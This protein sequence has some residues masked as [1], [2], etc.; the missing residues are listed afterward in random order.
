[1][2]AFLPFAAAEDSHLSVVA[3]T[4]WLILA[5]SMGL[6]GGYVLLL[7][8]AYTG[9]DLSQVYPIMRGINPL[10]VPIIGM[11]ALGERLGFVAW[12]GVAGIVAGI[13]LTGDFTVKSFGRSLANPSI[14][15]A[16]TVGGMISGYTVV[17]KVALSYFPPFT[18]NLATN[19]GN[20]FSLSFVVWNS[21]SL[22]RE[23]KVNW[24]TILLG[25]VLAPGGYLLFL[26]AMEHM[27]VSRIAPMRE[28]G[29]VFGT[30][31]GIFILH[32]RQ[33][34]RR[35]AASIIITIGIILLAG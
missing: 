15:L 14:L 18:L 24:T 9:G 34:R 10:L 17:D 30:L 12:I 25:G 5:G 22:I 6:H 31:L 33:G 28:I 1:V 2:I 8:R 35:I 21:G 29:T 16:L 26:H 23:W 7:A 32:E 13:I 3:L 19:L 20:L 27:P 11:V 4:G